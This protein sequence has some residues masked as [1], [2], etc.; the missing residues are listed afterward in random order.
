MRLL[1]C[2]QELRVIALGMHRIGGDNAS[3]QVQGLQQGRERGDLVRLAVH[4]SLGEHGKGALIEGSQQ[5]HGLPVTAGMP[6]SPH[7]LAIHGHRPAPAPPVLWSLASSPQPQLRLQPGTHRRIE[8]RGIHG[9]Q[10][11]ADGGLIR[12]REPAGQRVTADPQSSQDLRRRVRHPFTDR[13][14]RLRPGQHGCHR[15]Q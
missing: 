5:M 8:G 14:E 3:G 15:G 2:D 6:G 7:R 11:P 9:F 4:A 10:E 1:L 12:R 13:G